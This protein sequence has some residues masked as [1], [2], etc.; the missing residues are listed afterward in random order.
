MNSQPS[1]VSRRSIVAVGGGASPTIVRTS[2]RGLGSFR[3]DAAVTMVLTTAGAP[4]TKVRSWR[5][6]RRRISGP[7]DRPR[8]PRWGGAGVGGVVVAGAEPAGIAG[9]AGEHGGHDGAHP[10]RVGERCPGGGDGLGDAPLRVAHLFVEA[11][12]VVEVLE[13]QGVA[14]DLDGA[15]A[16][17]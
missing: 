15:G 11:A 14:G 10:E 12:Q 6:T 9:V 8:T 5:S 2:R 17:G 3:S 1:S 4:P 16:V 7:S 13:G